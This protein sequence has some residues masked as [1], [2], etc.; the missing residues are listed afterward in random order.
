MPTHIFQQKSSTLLAIILCL[1]P[2]LISAPHSRADTS[3][4]IISPCVCVVYVCVCVCVCVCAR[5][6]VR[7]RM[8]VCAHVW[9]L[10]P[11]LISAPHSQGWHKLQYI[12]PLLFSRLSPLWIIRSLAQVMMAAIFALAAV[13]AV[14]LGLVAP[15]AYGRSPTEW[16]SRVVYQ[17]SNEN[18]VKIL[19]IFVSITS[20]ATAPICRSLQTAL[21]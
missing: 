11:T 5:A 7:A 21:R 2:T 10:R 1:W 17:V 6:C 3:Y 19:Q 9:R 14:V 4:S 18:I 20:C 15:P 12:N 16:K 13:Y 8:R